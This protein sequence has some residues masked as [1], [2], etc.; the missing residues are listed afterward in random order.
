MVSSPEPR[1]RLTRLQ[2]VG[3]ATVGVCAALLCALLLFAHLTGLKVYRITSGS[4]SPTVPTGAVILTQRADA[5]EL[6]VG[7]VIT[8]QRSAES[9]TVTHRIVEIS[10]GEA[11]APVTVR[12]RGDA[13]PAPDPAPYRVETAQRYVFTLFAGDPP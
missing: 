8:T 12:L 5:A 13:N 9:R 1:Q 10:E 3:W 2:T 4:M 6:L 11:G 7:D